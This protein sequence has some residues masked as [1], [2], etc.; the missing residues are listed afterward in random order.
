VEC[1]AFRQGSSISRNIYPWFEW[2]PGASVVITNLPINTGDLVSVVVCAGAG[3]GANQATVLFNNLTTGASS[4]ANFTA[5][6]T[7]TLTG[8]CAEW[9]VEA[10]TINGKVGPLADYGQ[11][12][13]SS[14]SATLHS[15]TVMGVSAGDNIN[16][17]TGG[18]E[19]SAGS[20][21]TDSVVQCEYV[22][23]RP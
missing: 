13:F 8:N 10:P 14:S 18:T 22:G 4:G 17:V 21:V 3:A 16:L 6:G 2:W 19:E 23:T 1:E 15:N 12:F 9:I 11:V 20:L 5:P 7:L